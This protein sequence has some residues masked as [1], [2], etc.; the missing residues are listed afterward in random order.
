M[1]TRCDKQTPK[2]RHHFIKQTLLYAHK[3]IKHKGHTMTRS[4]FNHSAVYTMVLVYFFLTAVIICEEEAHNIHPYHLHIQTHLHI[5]TSKCVYR[6]IYV[7]FE[8]SASVCTSNQHV[9]W[10]YTHTHVVSLFNILWRYFGETYM[11]VYTKMT[12]IHIINK[13]FDVL[14]RPE[15][16]EKKLSSRENARTHYPFTKIHIS[17]KN[18]V[19]HRTLFDGCWLEK[20]RWLFNANSS[21]SF[22]WFSFLFFPMNGKNFIL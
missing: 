7:N 16:E 6:I 4:N 10:F 3:T 15:S 5:C 13:L 1:K 22:L 21:V 14:R 11:Y 19:Y 18:Y 17:N 2:N 9:V 8:Y 20:W 12:N